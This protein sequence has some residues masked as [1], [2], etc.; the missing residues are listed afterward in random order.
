MCDEA[1]TEITETKT[2]SH[3]WAA[4]WCSR[5]SVEVVLGQK[6]GAVGHVQDGVVDQHHL[7]EVKLVGESL[8]FGLV[9]NA[10]VVVIPAMEREEKGK[11][12]RGYPRRDQGNKEEEKEAKRED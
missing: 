1:A 2:P 5:A 9:Q 7:T 4:V 11:G 3:L 12:E 6:E 10:L 8:A